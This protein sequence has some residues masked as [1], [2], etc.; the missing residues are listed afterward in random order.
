MALA[1]MV[2]VKLREASPSTLDDGVAVV[3]RV[4]VGVRRVRCPFAVDDELVLVGS[5][6]ERL[7]EPEDVIGSL[8]EGVGTGAPAVEG[9]GDEDVFRHL[10]RFGFK[11]EVDDGE[12][13]DDE[14]DGQILHVAALE[15][16]FD[17]YGAGAAAG[18]GDAELLP[19]HRGNDLT[20]IEARWDG[21]GLNLPGSGVA[22]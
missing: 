10:S 7:A 18:P 21:I 8:H 20:D 13:L 12:G 19:V 5:R 1:S 16:G 22:E 3:G 17:G 11:L 2:Q 9:A 14:G 4:A 6:G 15:G